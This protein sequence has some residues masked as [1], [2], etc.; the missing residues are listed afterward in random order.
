MEKICASIV[1][2][3][4]L[5]FLSITAYATVWSYNYTYTNNQN[6]LNTTT[7]TNTS[8]NTQTYTQTCTINGVPTDCSTGQPLSDET[9][10][11]AWNCPERRFEI[12]YGQYCDHRIKTLKFRP[13]KIRHSYDGGGFYAGTGLTEAY[14]MNDNSEIVG[15]AINT[16]GEKHAVWLHIGPFYH[17]NHYF[18][19]LGTSRLTSAARAISNEDTMVGEAQPAIGSNESVD[20]IW[21]SQLGGF[22][23]LNALGGGLGV[24]TGLARNRNY[25][26]FVSG[27]GLW[28]RSVGGDDQEHGFVWSYD[29]RAQT[30]ERIGGSGQSTRA[31]DVN[32][33]KMAAGAVDS[34]G[35]KSAFRW[36]FGTLYLLKD[37]GNYPSEAFDVNNNAWAK[38][39][40]YAEDST[41]TKR[42]VL[43]DNG[44]FRPLPDLEGRSSSMAKAI[45]DGGDIVGESGGRATFWRERSP[46]D[47]NDLL[48]QNVGTTLTTAIDINRS[49]RILVKGADGFFYL[50][51]PVETL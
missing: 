50:L 43:W 23:H 9:T 37:Y 10:N 31:N 26:E 14:G 4:T 42:A 13:V 32:D 17:D 39:V 46:Y 38:I 7:Y 30:V 15:Q 21:H 16:S 5:M 34:G 48:D 28:P 41:N 20:V 11:S 8:T 40:G 3:F 47:L 18:S 27:Y 24:A 19:D 1:A 49:G 45:S 35:V 44:A 2:G 12:I 25:T 22:K 6:N 29:G 36:Q 51:V 33:S